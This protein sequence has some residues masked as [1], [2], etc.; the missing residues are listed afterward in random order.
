MTLRQAHVA[1][2]F[3][4]LAVV[5][6]T[7]F[8][9][10]GDVRLQH[11]SQAIA[12]KIDSLNGHLCINPSAD[13]QAHQLDSFNA[14]NLTLAFN[15]GEAYADSD[16]DGIPDDLE[17]NL[18][19]DPTKRRSDGVHL[20]GICRILG[21]PEKCAQLANLSNCDTKVNALGLSDC[22]VRAL[23]LHLLYAHPNQGIDSDKDGAPDLVEILRGT[24]PSRNDM[25]E[26]P[27]GDKSPNQAEL[28][29]G[30]DPR[31][32]D[33]SSGRAQSVELIR[34]DTADCP[35]GAFRFAISNVV[36]TPTKA[37]T[38]T[39]VPAVDSSGQISAL[40]FSHA[41][42]ENLILLTYKS[43]PISQQSNQAQ[44][45]G[46]VLKV[47][48]TTKSYPEI[49]PTDFHLLGTVLK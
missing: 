2:I 39:D 44:V 34:D 17:R 45:W 37:H 31:S 7:W 40:D 26:D 47:N 33:A 49:K 48:A 8:T 3:I 36:I 43:T 10:C 35:G 24:D 4:L 16:I 5:L 46:L 18:G 15:G 23:S 20:D 42:G 32:P 12:M 29:F 13:G 41:A 21:G 38:D 14:I 11:V 19:F 6:S 22:D 9:N 25:G 28:A 1:G 27:D 30:L